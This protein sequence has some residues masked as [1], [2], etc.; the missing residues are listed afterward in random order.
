M[1]ALRAGPTACQHVLLNYL[2]VQSIA[3]PA[4]AWLQ[5]VLTGLPSIG[6][7]SDMSLQIGD[8]VLTS[9]EFKW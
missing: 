2:Y 5:H 9:V 3:L 1:A 6:Y 7:N 8:T 4:G